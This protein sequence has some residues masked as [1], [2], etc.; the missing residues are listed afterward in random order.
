MAVWEDHLLPQLEFKEAARLG[1]T[2]KALRGLVR[3]KFRD[4][5]RIKLEKLQAALTTFP[6]ARTMAPYLFTWGEW[7]DAKA[8]TLREWLLG[9]GHAEGITIAGMT[10]RAGNHIDSL[11]ND[12]V[13]AALQGGVLPSLKALAADLQHGSHRATLT[14]ELVSG[15]HELSLKVSSKG[16]EAQLAALG[17]MR[18]LPALAKLEIVEE[19][20]HSVDESVQWP[21]FI[22]PSLK[23]LSIGAHDGKPLCLSLLCAL[24]GMLDARPPDGPF[25]N[26]LFW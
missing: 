20:D 23:A 5:G 13:H 15:M 16:I 18:Q 26:R 11:F 17:L 12:T 9:G 22:P 21:P 19:I 25:R 2:C 4:I 6:K 14:Y 3:E 7:G 8:Q 24:P 10:F 1:C